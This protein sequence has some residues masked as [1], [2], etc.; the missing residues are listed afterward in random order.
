VRRDRSHLVAAATLVFVALNLRM[1]IAALAPVLTQIQSDTGLGSAGSGLLAAVPVLCFGLVAPSTPGLGRR[2]GMGPLLGLTMG[3]V[4]VG[5]AIRLAPSLVALFAGTA[6]IGAGI[7]VANVVLPGLIKRDFH[8]EQGLMIALYAL[9][10]YVGAAFPAG[11][12]VPIEHLTGFGW[13]PAVAVWGIVALVALALWMPRARRGEEAAPA[14]HHAPPGRDLWRDRLAWA[15]TLCLGLQAF[16]YYATLSWLPA[17]F[18]SHGMSNGSAGWMLSYS[19]IPGAAASLAT[20]ALA[21]RVPRPG[22]LIVPAVALCALAYVGLAAAPTAAPYVWVTALGLGQGV[23]LA[24]AL[25]Y[26]VARARAHHVAHLSTMA[27]SVGYLI[28]ATGP[29][30]L[31]ALHGLT[32]SWTLPLLVLVG[33]L[34]PLCLAGL[35]AGHG[36]HVL[37]GTDDA[38]A[39]P[40]AAEP[41]A[42]AMSITKR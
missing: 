22:L 36:G 6:V 3:V 41:Q 20:P 40:R 16:G 13:R 14:A 10:L 2:F 28:A 5:A 29:F 31:G 17:I 23:A 37:P 9:S 26:I 7:A 39:R 27:Q 11:L 18:E 8:R 4:A 15:V 24:L 42:A 38:A 34:V 30:L 35:V 32:G 19:L 25:G 33:S 1:T 21:R 12:T